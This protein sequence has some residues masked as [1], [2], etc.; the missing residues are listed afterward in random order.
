MAAEKGKREIPEREAGMSVAVGSQG[1]GKSWKTKMLIYD[2]VKGDMASGVKGSKVI[3]MDTN[4]EYTD[5]EFVKMGMNNFSSKKIALD[6]VQSWCLSP[7]IECRRIDAKSLS[8]DEKLQTLEY[9][10]KVCRDVVLVIDDIN[11][12][13]LNVT[14]LREIVGGLVNLRHRACDVIVSYQSLRA[15][16]PR[17]YANC[18]WVRMHY[19]SDDVYDVKSKLP[20]PELFKIAQ[21]LVNKKYFGGDK[22]FYLFVMKADNKIKGKFSKRDFAEACMKYLN[23]NNKLVK[24]YQKENGMKEEEAMRSKVHHLVEMYYGN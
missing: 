15:V 22:R 4:G 14:H 7:L 19:Q 10:I 5:A 9:L 24:Q 17:I 1:V 11:T 16:E 12:Y 18:R 20:N 2:M 13:V 23:F 8:M 21:I 6:D 3:V